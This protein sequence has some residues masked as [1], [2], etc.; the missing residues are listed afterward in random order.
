MLP[1]NSPE[2]VAMCNREGHRARRAVRFAA[3][4]L[5]TFFRAVFLRGTFFFAV[6][7]FA[8]FFEVFPLCLLMRPG[9]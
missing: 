1:N 5:A 4:F 8:V 6:F 9:R 7:F 3:F 2:C